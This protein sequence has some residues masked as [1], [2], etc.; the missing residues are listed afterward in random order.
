[1]TPNPNAILSPIQFTL[2]C[3]DLYNFE[4]ATVFENPID[5][6]CGVYT[7]DGMVPGV[8]W[9][10]LWYRDGKLVH[11]ETKPWGDFTGG[12]DFVEWEAPASEW[13]PGVYEVQISS[14]WSGR[15]WDSS[16]WKAMRRLRVLPD[17]LANTHAFADAD[18]HPHRHLDA[19]THPNQHTAP[20]N[21]ATGYGYSIMSLRGVV[22]WSSTA[23]RRIETRRY[24]EAIPCSV[25]E[26]RLRP[27]GS[28]TLRVRCQCEENKKDHLCMPQKSFRMSIPMCWRTA[29]VVAG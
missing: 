19:Y 5:Y 9:T 6:M 8:Q 10:A 13:L 28:A 18:C 24:D 21:N 3:T 25:C 16:A 1:M 22:C 2:N 20:Y 27:A 7:F 26:L 17:S 11:Y 23:Q 15:L 4:S 29:T 12:Y 14:D